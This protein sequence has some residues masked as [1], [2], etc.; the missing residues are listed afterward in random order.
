M[1]K[2]FAWEAGQMKMSIIE[3]ENTQ[4][5]ARVFC[6]LKTCFVLWTL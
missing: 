5:G 3:I 4:Q 1:D 2:F 6:A